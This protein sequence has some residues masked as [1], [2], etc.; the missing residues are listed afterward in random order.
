MFIPRMWSSEV[1]RIGKQ[2]CTPAGYVL[3]SIGDLIG[4]AGLLL[5][6]ALPLYL[7]YRGIAGT[8][9]WSL[10]WFLLL[11]FGIGLLGLIV[12]G[13]SWHM[14]NKKYFKY[15]YEKNLSTWYESGQR[16]C[17]PPDNPGQ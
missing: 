13:F 5:L 16:C 7:V 2:K 14:A 9:L 3:H 17:H 15:D 11:P 6:L 4:F 12:V 10:L 1:E 8:F